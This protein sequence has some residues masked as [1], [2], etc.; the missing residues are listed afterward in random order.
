MLTGIG[1]LYGDSVS[2]L[3]ELMPGAEIFDIA[4]PWAEGFRF[5]EDDFQVDSIDEVGPAGHFLDQ[6]HALTCASSGVRRY[7]PS[8]V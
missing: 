7:R 2:S 6:A 8:H 5:D 1:S 4:A 3:T